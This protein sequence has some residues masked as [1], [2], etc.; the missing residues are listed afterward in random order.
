MPDGSVV[1][2]EGVAL[3]AS[4][5]GDG[6]G[7][8]AD[9]TGGIA[10]LLSDGS[11]QRGDLLRV[12]GEV[13]DRFSQR[14][15]RATAADVTVVGAGSDPAAQ[16]LGTGELGE[17]QEGE[18]VS[19]DGSIV[20]SLS[21]LTS[22]VALDVDDGSGP[23]RVQVAASSGIVTD[24]WS[25][26]SRLALRGVVGQRDSSGTG[27]SGYRVQPR[28]Q[29]D[30]LALTPPSPSPSA[31][32]TPGGGSDVM[33]VAAARAMPFNS[34]LAVRG[35]V[36]LPADLVEEGTAV[37]QDATGCIALRL[38]EEART[39]SL[40]QLVEMRGTRA[41]KAGMETLRVTEAPAQ[42]GSRPEPEARRRD[43][44]SAGEADEAC[45]LVVRGIVT[46]TP[47]RTS[48]ENVYFDIDDGSGPL[49]VFVAPGTGIETDR[50]LSGT[51]VQVTGVLGQE[52]SGSLPLRGYRLWPRAAGDLR[53]VAQPAGV[54]PTSGNG[55][56]SH[57]QGHSSASGGGAPTGATPAATARMPQQEQPVL[58]AAHGVPRAPIATQPAAA[59]LP[60]AEHSAADQSPVAAG[61]LLLAALMLLGAGVATGSPDLTA[62]LLA[63]IRGRLAGS[64]DADA[65]MPSAT[66]GDEHDADAPPAPLPQLVPLQVLEPVPAAGG[67]SVR[68]S[69]REHERILP[70]T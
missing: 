44:G 25:R 60:Q 6:G 10:V 45:L 43:T 29:L 70:P 69:R 9:A 14:T 1:L 28:D 30:V 38:G 53:I 61:L 65:G 35:V 54:P 23:V 21:L 11:F 42:L 67:R 41:T 63:A 19:I 52:T 40:G 7:Y 3:T 66:E 59:A 8:L 50:L 39:M 68:A 47:R 32:P 46:L 55:P 16:T 2:V 48:A 34:R 4:D 49:R 56:T 22:G 5:F 31:S 37:I 12:Q 15:L 17:G 33:T 51:V 62:R 20:S 57:G 36:T 27:L 64:S 13:D 24:G 26:G 18:L 58:T